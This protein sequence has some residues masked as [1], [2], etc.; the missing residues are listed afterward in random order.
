MSVRQGA[1]GLCERKQAGWLFALGQK[2][3]FSKLVF[4]KWV[5]NKFE[6]W[7]GPI[8]TIKQC[9]SMNA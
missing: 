6:F 4:S 1:A 3:R 9:T 8:I 7:Q 5:L 2:E